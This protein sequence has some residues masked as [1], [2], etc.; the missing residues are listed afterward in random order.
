M[1]DENP[2]PIEPSLADEFE[3]ALQ[4]QSVDVRVHRVAIQSSEPMDIK[5]IAESADCTPDTALRHVRNLVD[6]GILVQTTENP[7]KFALDES[8]LE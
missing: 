7:K 2:P 1:S 4:S 3:N 5:F 8:Y 6:G